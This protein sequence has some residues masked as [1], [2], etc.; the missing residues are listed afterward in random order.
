M[1]TVLKASFPKVKATPK[2]PA[3]M[4]MEPKISNGLRPSFST[5]KTATSV[6]EIFT[7]PM[8]TV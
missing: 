4:P 2:A 1:V 3:A 6:N 5:V 7:T 8:M